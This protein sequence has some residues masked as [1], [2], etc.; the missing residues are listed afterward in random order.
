V[1]AELGRI[2]ERPPSFIANFYDGKAGAK[3]E[4]GFVGYQDGG[5]HFSAQKE[6]ALNKQ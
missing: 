5:S 4:T 6:R 1:V 3:G 2:A